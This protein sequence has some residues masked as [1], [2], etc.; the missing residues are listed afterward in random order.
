MAKQ[1][2]NWSVKTDEEGRIARV[3]HSRD[4]HLLA[5]ARAVRSGDDATVVGYDR[6]KHRTYTYATYRADGHHTNAE[7]VI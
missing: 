7:V 2:L 4:A 6:R 1:T 5:W 3:A